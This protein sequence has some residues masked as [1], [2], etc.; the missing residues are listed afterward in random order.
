MLALVGL[1]ACGRIGFGA[2]DAD[3]GGHDEDGDGRSD[4]IDLCPHVADD[5]ADTD[6]DRVGDACDPNPT[7]A[8]EK[9]AVFATMTPGD[10]PFTDVSA[11]VQEADALRFSGVNTSL[12]LQ[13]AI[14]S[15]RIDLGFEIHGLVGEGQHQVAYGIEASSPYYFAE[16]NEN[17]AFGVRNAG[18]VEYT[19]ANGYVHLASRTHAGMHPG[20]GYLRLDTDADNRQLATVMGWIGELYDAQAAAPGY[21]G[22][23]QVR[24]TFN[25][26]DLSLRYLVVI[27]AL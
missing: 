14:A 19:D 5:N 23:A 6:G 27:S 15:T 3:P 20:V 7:T 25:G 18:L 11:F 4:A 2:D 22:G 13:H 10:H 1:A 17:N 16:L 26:L 9:L 21:V 24:F 12:Y 8:T